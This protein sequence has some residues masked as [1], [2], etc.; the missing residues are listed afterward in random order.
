MRHG[1]SRGKYPQMLFLFYLKS[2]P[3]KSPILVK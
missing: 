3:K 1:G 2:K